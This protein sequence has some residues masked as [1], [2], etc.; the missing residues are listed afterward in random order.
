ML[1]S[2]TSPVIL[3]LVF[4]VRA[5]GKEVGEWSNRNLLEMYE[6]AHAEVSSELISKCEG[7]RFPDYLYIFNLFLIVSFVS[8]LKLF[9][10]NKT[11]ILQ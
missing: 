9:N 10:Q 3:L 7:W 1:T 5:N 4:V 8:K 2:N 11:K 6:I